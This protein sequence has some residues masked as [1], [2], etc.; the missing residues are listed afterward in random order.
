MKI[1]VDEMPKCCYDCLF[2]GTDCERY[3]CYCLLSNVEVGDS[4]EKVSEK[5]H[6]TCPLHSTTEFKAEPKVLKERWK[7]LKD[8]VKKEIVADNRMIEIGDK[9]GYR[10]LEA[11]ENIIGEMQKLEQEGRDEF[12]G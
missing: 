1:F 6:S 10:Y 3:P 9:D 7:K 4:N 11:D 2:Y 5:K 12:H 8:F